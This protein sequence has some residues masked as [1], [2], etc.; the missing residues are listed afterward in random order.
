LTCYQCIGFDRVWDD[1][2]DKKEDG[3]PHFIVYAEPEGLIDK[4]NKRKFY[5]EKLN[6]LLKFAEPKH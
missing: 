2:C 1:Y 6:T 5:L 4:I 3:K